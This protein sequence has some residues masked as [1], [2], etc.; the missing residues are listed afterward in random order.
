MYRDNVFCLQQLAGDKCIIGV[1][2]EVA[3][4]RK[5]CVFKGVELGSSCIS[6]NSAVSPAK[7]SLVP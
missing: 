6:L 3:A 1:H 7:Y 2:S 4:D 5:H